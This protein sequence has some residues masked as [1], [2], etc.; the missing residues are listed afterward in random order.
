MCYRR[1]NPSKHENTCNIRDDNANELDNKKIDVNAQISAITS[2]LELTFNILFLIFVVDNEGITMYNLSVAIILYDIILP[3]VFLMNTSHNKKRIVELGWENVF[4]NILGMSNNSVEQTT[5]RILDKKRTRT[6]TSDSRVQRK[7]KLKRNDSIKVF[8]T[9]SSSQIQS[10]E[11]D[12]SSSVVLFNSGSSTC[13]HAEMNRCVILGAKES[14]KQNDYDKLIN[15]IVSS[16]INFENDEKNYISCLKKLLN[17]QN[18]HIAGQVLTDI[19][20]EDEFPLVCKQI[21][22]D[23]KKGP[24]CKGKYSKSLHP[25]ESMNVQLPNSCNYQEENK[26]DI[27]PLRLKG[28]LRD[29]IIMRREILKHI[30]KSCDR[31]KTFRLIE[32]LIDL[33]EGFV[34]DD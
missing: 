12:S 31:D 16:M 24:R 27:I 17:A 10:K 33:E 7:K 23:R 21:H 22:R 9:P 20:L 28:E 4:K 19:E 11:D 34:Q 30:Y 14:L 13:T 25:Q 3:Y 2:I 32:N 29:R 8:A 15:R 26:I 6:F 1:I 5:T 18:S